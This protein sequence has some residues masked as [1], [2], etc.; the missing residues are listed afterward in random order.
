MY[1]LL[2]LHCQCS[3]DATVSDGMVMGHATAQSHPS[4]HSAV[5]DG[6]HGYGMPRPT[7]AKYKYL[8]TF[9]FSVTRLKAS[10]EAAMENKIRAFRS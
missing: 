2:H 6:V 3:N 9:N 5:G 10:D 4:V 1:Q 8:L 7:T